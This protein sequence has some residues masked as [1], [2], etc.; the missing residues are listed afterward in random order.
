MVIFLFYSPCLEDLKQRRDRARQIPWGVVMET[1]SDGQW[2]SG[3]LCRNTR[4]GNSTSTTRIPFARIVQ[5]VPLHL[6]I[7]LI[8]G[9][10]VSSAY[11]RSADNESASDIEKNSIRVRLS[12]SCILK[13]IGC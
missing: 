6:R 4:I 5:C 11:T 13:N 8:R 9:L 12:V 3:P 2:F 7:F 1:A 10:G